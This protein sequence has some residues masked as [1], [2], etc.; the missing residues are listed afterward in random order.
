[1]TFHDDASLGMRAR[2]SFVI[3]RSAVEEIAKRIPAN[4]NGGRNSSPALMTSHVE[5][6][7]KHRTAKTRLGALDLKCSFALQKTGWLVSM[8]WI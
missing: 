7:I 2:S 3:T 6:Q 4:R 8:N 5:P 1:M